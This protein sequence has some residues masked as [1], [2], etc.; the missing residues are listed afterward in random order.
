LARLAALKI[1]QKIIDGE[2]QARRAAIDDAKIPRAVTDTGRGDSEE[3][4][5]GVACHEE[6]SLNFQ[7]FE[8]QPELSPRLI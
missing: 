6:R 5:E 3:F 1:G 2:G 8:F 4:A 7:V